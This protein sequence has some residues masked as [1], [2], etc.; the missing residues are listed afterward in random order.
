MVDTGHSGI[1]TN[2]SGEVTR[3]RIIE[4]AIGLMAEYGFAAIT[5][6]SV[7]DRAG[8]RYGNLTHHYS[9]RDKLIEALLDA[10]LERYRGQF[11]ELATAIA[12]NRDRALGGIVEW[13][14][15]DAV[16]LETGPVFLELWAMANHMPDVARAMEALYDEAVIACVAA[17]GVSMDAAAQSGLRDAL[18]LL[19]TVIEGSSAIFSSRPRDTDIYRGFRREA[20]EMLVGTLESRLEAARELD[21]KRPA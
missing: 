17:L 18:Y 4:A 7:A 8:I 15:D 13:L 10:L 9:T 14:L 16:K 11:V 3:A 6:Q 20:F 5:L 2:R 21:S 12:Q 19:G 1:R